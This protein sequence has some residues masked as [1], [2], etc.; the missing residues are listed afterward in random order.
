MVMIRRELPRTRG[1]GWVRRP[2]RIEVEEGSPFRGPLRCHRLRCPAEHSAYLGRLREL[3]LLF[4]FDSD[5]PDKAEQFASDPSHNLIFVLTARRHRFVP[6]MQPLLGLPG[7]L[8]RFLADGQILLSSQQ[9][10]NHIWPMLIRP[11]RF[12]DHTSEVAVAG[13]GDP[14]AL[15]PVAAGVL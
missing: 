9:Q 10:P 14:A 2:C 11:S 15:H 4:G 6:F 12:P 7:D 13:L 5:S 3:L 1:A 8:L